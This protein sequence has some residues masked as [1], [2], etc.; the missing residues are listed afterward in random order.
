MER[1]YGNFSPPNLSPIS[2]QSSEINN[3]SRPRS[4][5]RLNF[6]EDMSIDTP[7]YTNFLNEQNHLA[8][9][10]YLEIAS[11]KKL[12]IIFIFVSVH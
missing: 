10:I 1:K 8:G 9:N 11:L 3:K 2:N 4:V 12:S 5:T 7:S 6:S